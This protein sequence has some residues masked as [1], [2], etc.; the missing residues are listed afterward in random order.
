VRNRTE[1]FVKFSKYG[2]E[3]GVQTFGRH[4]SQ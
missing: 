3:A 2:C 1:K 4:S